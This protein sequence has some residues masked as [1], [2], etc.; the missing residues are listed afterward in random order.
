MREPVVVVEYDQ[1]WE[2][3]F[4]TLRDGLA[5][6]LNELVGS[7]EH[8]GSTAIPGVAAKP[9]IDM[10]V[11]ARSSEDVGRITEKPSSRLSA[12]RRPRNSRA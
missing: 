9:I 7:I 12:R 6:F 8:V 3:I 2:E 4:R 11:V 10:D 5:P 1:H